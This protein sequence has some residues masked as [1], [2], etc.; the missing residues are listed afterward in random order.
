MILSIRMSWDSFSPFNSSNSL[1]KLS[2]D[3]SSSST[4][5]VGGFSSKSFAVSD[6]FCSFYFFSR[7]TISAYFLFSASISFLFFTFELASSFIWSIYF[8]RS[9]TF[10]WAIYSYLLLAL[11]MSSI[12]IVLLFLTASTYSSFVFLIFSWASLNLSSTFIL[13]SSWRYWLNSS[14]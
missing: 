13:K 7:A 4:G 9:F 3:G 10:F 14:I 1:I 2:V 8:C 5:G 12:R 11:S 6:S